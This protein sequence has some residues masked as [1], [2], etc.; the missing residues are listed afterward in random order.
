MVIL[1]SFSELQDYILKQF[2]HSIDICCVDEKTISIGT[3][4][5]MPFFVKQINLCLSV[6]KIDG[7]DITM[8]YSSGLGIDLIMKGVL[9]FIN[10]M[11]PEYGDIVEDKTANYFTIHLKKIKQLEKTFDYVELKHI[12]FEESGVVIDVSLL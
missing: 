1:I 6:E 3:M 5:K 11:S 7:Y 9:K 4:I 8:S 12:H 10:G 2:K